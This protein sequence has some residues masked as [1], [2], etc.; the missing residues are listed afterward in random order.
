MIKTQQLVKYGL[1][2]VPID[3]LRNYTG[4]D[5]WFFLYFYI[6]FHFI[7]YLLDTL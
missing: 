2:M 7:N 3:Y 4:R 1:N 6:F 5:D